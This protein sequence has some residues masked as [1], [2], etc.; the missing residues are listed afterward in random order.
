VRDSGLR[1]FTFPRGTRVGPGATLTVHVGH[2]RRAGNDF[3]WGLGETIFEDSATG[4]GDG[5]GAYVFDPHG[6]LRVWSIYPC[7]VS[8]TDPEQGAFRIHANPRGVEYVSVTNVSDRARDLY[9]YGLELVGGVYPFAAG[10]VVPPGRTMTVYT[11]GSPGE[12]TALVR[13]A[14]IGGYHL[15]DG[16]GRVLLR[17]FEEVVLACDAWGDG[18]C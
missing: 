10:S 15:R 8:C 14:G 6:D 3:Y 9:G 12:D 1:R 13:H 7:L 4:H 18:S 16:G 17:N 5:D 2:G 11:G